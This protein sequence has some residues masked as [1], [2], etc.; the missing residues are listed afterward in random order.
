M[1]RRMMNLLVITVPFEEM[2]TEELEQYERDPEVEV[3]VDGDRQVV[4]IKRQYEDN[5]WYNGKD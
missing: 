2:T 5:G 1:N 3:K 4:V